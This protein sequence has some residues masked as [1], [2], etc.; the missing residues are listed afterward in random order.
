MVKSCWGPLLKASSGVLQ[1]G[2]TQDPGTGKRRRAPR[3]GAEAVDLE[4][5]FDAQLLDLGDPDDGENEA[6]TADPKMPKVE[7]EEWGFDSEWTWRQSSASPR[8]TQ[9]LGNYLRMGIQG[10]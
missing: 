4:R 7:E 10:H 9:Q 1:L 8:S 5:D 6:E 2:D 3:R